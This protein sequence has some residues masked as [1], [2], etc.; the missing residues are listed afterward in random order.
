VDSSAA[1]DVN[2]LFFFVNL[3]MKGRKEKDTRKAVRPAKNGLSIGFKR[4]KIGI[5][6]NKR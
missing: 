5:A 4:P 2:Q 6:R 3:I 1:R